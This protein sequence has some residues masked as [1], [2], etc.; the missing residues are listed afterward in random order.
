[1]TPMTSGSEAA[2]T[3]PNT[4]ISSTSVIGSAM[5]S[6]RSRS[7]SMVSPTSWYTSAK[8]PTSTS[9]AAAPPPAQCS[10]RGASSVTRSSTWSS[11]PSTLATTRARLPL[12]LRSG[13]AFPSDQY[14]TTS[15]TP[16]SDASWSVRA[17]PAVTTAGSSTSPFWAVTSSNRLGTPVSNRSASALSA[18]SD[19]EDGSSKPPDVRWSATPPPRAPASANM[20]IATTTTARAWFVDSR[21]NRVSMVR[22]PSAGLT[23]LRYRRYRTPGL[24][25]CRGVIGHT[26]R[27]VA[28]PLTSGSVSRR[29]RGPRR[30][31]RDRGDRRDRRARRHRGRQLP[32]RTWTRSHAGRR[33]PRHP[34]GRQRVGGRRRTAR[35]PGPRWLRLRPHLRRL[36]AHAGGRR[37]ARRGLGPA[38]ARRL[39]ARRALLVGGRPTGR[40]GGGG[41]GVRRPAADRRPLEGRRDHRAVRRRPAAPGEPPHQHR[42]AAVAPQHARRLRPRAHQAHGG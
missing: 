39:G 17:W 40:R 18:R 22:P 37:M 38:G 6:A 41:L 33:L 12:S 10:Y 8:P 1:M 30:D 34:P 36:R 32:G 11:V 3:L 21:A 25:P 20:R 9:T 7:S 29:D 4:R 13:G 31:R 15:A 19:S 14:D 5:V 35:R 28:R 27:G 16:G 24:R 42:R 2:T 26:G 23:E